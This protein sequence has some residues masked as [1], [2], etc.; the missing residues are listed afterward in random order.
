VRQ[1]QPREGPHEVGLHLDTSNN[2]TLLAHDRGMAWFS[3]C[4]ALSA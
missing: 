4:S 2:R 3:M 1:H